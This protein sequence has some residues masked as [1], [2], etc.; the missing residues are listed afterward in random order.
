MK[1]CLCGFILA[2]LVG[3]A[4]AVPARVGYIVDGDTFSGVVKLEGGVDVSVRVRIRNVDTPEI[5]GDCEYERNIAASAREKL[6]QIIPVGTMV[7]LTNVKDDKYLG[8]ID[9]NVAD[10]SGADVG[11]RLIREGFGRPYD[12]GRRQPWCSPAHKK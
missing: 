9:A 11:A 8:R 7:E 12:G 6:G 3:N 5:H 2:F 4:V 1:R 10:A